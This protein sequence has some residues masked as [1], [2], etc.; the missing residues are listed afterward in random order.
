MREIIESEQ[1]YI[2]GFTICL[3]TGKG[4]AH[5]PETTADGSKTVSVDY[6][7]NAYSTGE[8]STETSY[9]AY[10][11]YVKLDWLTKEPPKYVL[12]QA[13]FRLFADDRKDPSMQP[14][15]A[16]YHGITGRSPVKRI[17][18]HYATSIKG[19]GHLFHRAWEYVRQSRSGYYAQLV[20]FN[21]A[22]CANTLDEIY[23]LE[24]AAVARSTL[25]P[26]GLNAIP[27]GHA[28]I[29]EMWRLGLM[30][31]DKKT[32]EERDAA[33]ADLEQG[34]GPVSVHYRRGHVRNLPASSKKT[35][36]WVTA[37]VV[38][39]KAS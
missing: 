19:E 1:G 36:T 21:F 13:W 23:T 31:R 5:E 2:F 26:K 15:L 32:P 20:V 28:G 12:Y 10:R 8:F 6:V 7:V 11:T 17:R 3:T 39:L 25:A 37:C 30:S 34:R 18:E 29:R 33:M 35:T 27:G 16:G 4:H 9:C 14:F 24:E 22:D 38:G